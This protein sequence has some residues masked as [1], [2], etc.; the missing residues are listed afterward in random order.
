MPQE[1]TK[2]FDVEK[3]KSIYRTAAACFHIVW[4][5]I[6]NDFSACLERV[7]HFSAI[8]HYTVISKHWCRFIHCFSPLETAL[9]CFPDIL[10]QSI[11]PVG[12]TIIN[13]LHV[14]S[15]NVKLTFFLYPTP[16]PAYLTQRRTV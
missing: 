6:N 16:S 9:I 15:K 3:L 10:C 2:H 5:L 13:Y 7:D 8:F 4:C 14:K 1:S 12:Y 11:H